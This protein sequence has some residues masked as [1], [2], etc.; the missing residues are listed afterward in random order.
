M[1]LDL[2]DIRGV[3]ALADKLCHGTLSNPEGV[4][5]QDARLRDVRVPRMD[6]IICN[7]AYGGWSGVQWPKAIWTILTEG[8]VQSVTWPNFKKALPTRLLNEQPGYG[9]V[10]LPFLRFPVYSLLT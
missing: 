6:T 5:G 1:Q 3:Y 4:E 9:Y 8:I 2:C 7:A 10:W